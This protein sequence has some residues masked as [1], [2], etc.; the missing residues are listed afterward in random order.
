MAT[1]PSTWVAAGDHT[2]DRRGA[3]FGA[4]SPNWPFV[5]GVD[6]AANGRA[7]TVVAFGDSITDGFQSAVARPAGA[8]DTRWPDVLARRLVRAARPL[9]VVNEGI[10]GNRVRL[11]A[12]P[13]SPEIFGPSGLSR[14]DGDVLATAGV[15]DA[16]LLEGINDLGQTPPATAAQIIAGLQQVVTRLQVAGVRVHLGT[17]TPSGGYGAPTYGSPA[18]DAIRRTVDRW[19]RR[20]RLPDTVVDFDAAVRDPSQPGRLRPAYDSGDHL[21]PNARGYRA[22]GRA[23]RLSAL[24]GRRCA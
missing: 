18:A 14:L 21:H 1:E 11:D 3:A 12:L 15:T 16:I 7:G 5:D 13:S 8:R 4:P 2:G 20:S 23:V 24:H 10:S 6:V 22:M 19:V 17:L 9:S